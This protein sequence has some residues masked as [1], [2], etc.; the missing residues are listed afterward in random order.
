MSTTTCT[1]WWA[2]T[3]ALRPA[4]SRGPPPPSGTSWPPTPWT[5]PSAWPTSRSSRPTLIRCRRRC[6]SA[7]SRPTKRRCSRSCR[8]LAGDP[9]GRQLAGEP[10]AVGRAIEVVAVLVGG[11]RVDGQDDRPTA[12]GSD[13]GRRDRVGGEMDVGALARLEAFGEYARQEPRR[14]AVVEPVRGPARGELQLDRH[15]V[16][17]SR[18][19]L[20]TPDLEPALT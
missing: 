14:G 19:D 7:T 13:P 5:W 4:R 2:T 20:P 6:T 12:A 15:G 16:T 3:P 10:D 11:G 17:L 9:P 8:D 18:P 1:W